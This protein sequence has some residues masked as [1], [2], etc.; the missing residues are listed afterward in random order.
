MKITILDKATLG[1][2]IDLS[3]IEAIAHPVCYET[4]SPDEVASRIS[5]TDVVIV[6]KIKLNASNLCDARQLKLICVAATGYDNIDL[7]YCREHGIALCNVPGYST[8]SVAQLTLSMALSLYTRLHDYRAFVHGGEYSASG[9]ANKLTPVYHEIAG[10]TFGVVGGGQIATRVAGVAQALGCDVWMCRR[11]DEGNFPRCDIDALCQKADILSI[12]LPLTEQT[13][14]IISR[15]RI[16]S[17]KAGA[18]VINTARGAVCD[19]AALADAI[20][21]GHLGGLGVDV[22]ST[23]P[24]GTDHPFYALLDR[25]NVCFTPHMAWGAYESRNRCVAIVAQNIRAFFDGAPQNRI[26]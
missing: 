7:A 10:K 20:V 4:T 2:D 3:P 12:H 15:E 8:D 24:F 14:G 18:V 1:E 23:E 9:V 5:D 11:K 17:M 13:R 26:V 19:E 16:E 21:S 25:T 22:Y 6:N